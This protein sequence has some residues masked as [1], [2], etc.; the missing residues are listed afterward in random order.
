LCSSRFKHCLKE[1]I[2][3]IRRKREKNKNTPDIIGAFLFK[4]SIKALFTVFMR[5]VEQFY[6]GGP[7]Q[8][9]VN[10]LLLI[11]LKPLRRYNI[12]SWCT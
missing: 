11:T 12:M 4:L 2:K 9:E 6:F 3:P 10:P 5:E 8:N 7:L 1:N